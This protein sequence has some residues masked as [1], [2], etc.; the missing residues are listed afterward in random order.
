MSRDDAGSARRDKRREQL[1]ASLR[2]NLKRRKTQKRLRNAEERPAGDG[3][4]PVPSP[5][6][7]G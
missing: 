7:K 5:N 6:S 3:K 2:E 1:A 4:A